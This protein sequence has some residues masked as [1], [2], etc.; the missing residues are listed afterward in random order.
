MKAVAI[1]HLYSVSVLIVLIVTVI[2]YFSKE[3]QITTLPRAHI[4]VPFPSLLTLGL[5]M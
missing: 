2:D 3:S 5:A 1:W 4:I